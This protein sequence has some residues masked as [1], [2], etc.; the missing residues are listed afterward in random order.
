MRRNLATTQ[1]RPR[2]LLF[3][4]LRL[5]L[6]QYLCRITSHDVKR[7]NILPQV[8]TSSLIESRTHLCHNTT[9]SHRRTIPNRHPR[10]YDHIAGN[11]AVLPDAD[12]LAGL[13]SIC[14]IPQIRLKGVCSA[15][16]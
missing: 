4:W 9:R 16:K 3:Q 10:Q 12:G 13:G 7:R 5:E 2:A 11:P 1:T 8:R 14:P 15:V 6:P